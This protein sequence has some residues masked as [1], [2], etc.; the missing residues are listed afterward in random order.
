MPFSSS[1][2]TSEASVY[3]GGGWVNF[4]SLRHLEKA[5]P[6]A[7]VQRGQHVLLLGLRVVLTLLVDHGEAGEAAASARWRAGST[8][9]PSMSA[10][11]VS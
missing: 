5:R 2:R 9:S 6:G 8:P 3:R 10:E 7:L 4:C 11:S 1:A